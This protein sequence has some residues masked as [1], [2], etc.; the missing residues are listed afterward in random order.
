VNFPRIKG[1]FIE[2]VAI[3]NRAD[4]DNSRS[5]EIVSALANSGAESAPTDVG[6]YS[7]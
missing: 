2:R 5:S 6:G 3:P 1:M 7:G 4:E